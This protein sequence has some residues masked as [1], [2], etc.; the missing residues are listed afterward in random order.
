[1]ILIALLAAVTVTAAA[2]VAPQGDVKVPVVVKQVGA[3]PFTETD[4]NV[5]WDLDTQ[6]AT[7]M[8]PDVS[9]LVMYFGKS[10]DNAPIEG[11]GLPR[12]PEEQIEAM[13]QRDSL[14]LLS[15][16]RPAVAAR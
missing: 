3:G 16:E 15:L 4:G 6:A 9:R 2:P 10:L 1:M 8:A 12:V 14:S 7:G 13:I 11:T 5:E